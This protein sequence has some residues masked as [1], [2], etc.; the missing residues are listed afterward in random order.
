[1]RKETLGEDAWN[2]VKENYDFLQRNLDQVQTTILQ[3]VRKLQKLGK[4]RFILSR[5]QNAAL[6][7][8][9]DA[10]EESWVARDW[11]EFDISHF[12][13]PE[14]L[15]PSLLNMVRAAKEIFLR[16]RYMD[17]DNLNALLDNVYL[18]MLFFLFF[19]FFL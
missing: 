8:L 11:P 4:Y 14:K 15:S 19:F 6:E 13:A 3:P 2:N 18:F 9:V 10:I 1:V 12:V 16:L 17:H 5:D 7:A